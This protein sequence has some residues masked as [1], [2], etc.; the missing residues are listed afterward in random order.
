MQSPCWDISKHRYAVVD[1]KTSHRNRKYDDFVHVRESILPVFTR[2]RAL[3]PLSRV[4]LAKRAENKRH[5]APKSNHRR[6]FKSSRET[7]RRQEASL[8]S[9]LNGIGTHR[10]EETRWNRDRGRH[11]IGR[12]WRQKNN[13]TEKVEEWQWDNDRGRTA[14]GTE[15]Q[16]KKSDG[17]EAPRQKTG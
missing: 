10:E 1:P 17:T 13:G 5:G 7:P 2:L 16:R 4:D 6:Q 14:M 9:L 12:R 15:T 3:P 8:L 11:A